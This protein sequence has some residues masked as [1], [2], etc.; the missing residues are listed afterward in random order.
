MKTPL[1]SIVFNVWSGSDVYRFALELETLL[2]SCRTKECYLRLCRETLQRWEKNKFTIP[3]D[4]FSSAFTLAGFHPLTFEID[5]LELILAHDG[6]ADGSRIKDIFDS[7][8]SRNEIKSQCI[9]GEKLGVA[10][11]R[12]L[13]M[14]VF[15]GEYLMFRDDDDY[16][17]PAA[18]L[19]EYAHKLKNIGFGTNNTSYWSNLPEYDNIR[20]RFEYFHKYQI[21][22]T[23]AIMLDGIKLKNTWGSINNPFSKTPTPIDTYKVELVD[24]SPQTSMCTKIFSREALRGINNSVS[25]GS[26]EDARSHYLQQLPQHCCWFINEE[27]LKEIQFDCRKSREWIQANILGEVMKYEDLNFNDFITTTRPSFVYV[28]PTGSYSYTSWSYC[29]VMGVLEAFRN[30]R[31]QLD[32]SIDD[33]RRLKDIIES[34]IETTL[35]RVDSQ[36]SVEWCSTAYKKEGTKLASILE[37]INNYRF[38]YW[39]GIVHEK[40][41]W[42]MFKNKISQIKNLINKITL[43]EKSNNADT[44]SD[45]PRHPNECIVAVVNDEERLLSISNETRSHSLID[46]PTS[47]NYTTYLPKSEPVIRGGHENGFNL[48]SISFVIILIVIIF[49]L[50]NQANE[51]SIDESLS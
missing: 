13:A 30:A 23:I 28:C 40:S 15:K 6:N 9:S 24:R 47:T 26:L 46:I 39:F 41:D 17:A 11:M 7:F 18:L 43:N 4:Y 32:F 50:C 42:K 51:I 25:L 12:N 35:I 1:L 19:L 33:I 44:I 31:K 36:T 10:G 8:C 48:L 16:T 5:E 34:A 38:I 3:N 21:K 14:Q 49:I 20:Q 2:W 27:K 37:S 45:V 29:S 22:P